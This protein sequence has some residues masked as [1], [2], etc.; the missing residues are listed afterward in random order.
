MRDMDRTTMA[1]SLRGEDKCASASN[2]DVMQGGC[3]QGPCIVPHVDVSSLTMA[4][5]HST[6]QYDLATNVLVPKT[7]KSGH[8]T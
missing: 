5:Y 6:L 8:R 4:K 7:L 1:Y 3:D 2:T